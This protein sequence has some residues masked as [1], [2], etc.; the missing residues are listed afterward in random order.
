MNMPTRSSER[1]FNPLCYTGGID[2][3]VQLNLDLDALVIREH[4]IHT[5]VNIKF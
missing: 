2:V 5:N 4:I 1:I 3:L